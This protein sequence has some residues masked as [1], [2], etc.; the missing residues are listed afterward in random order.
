MHTDVSL[1]A[2]CRRISAAFA[3]VLSL[4]SRRS[5]TSIVGLSGADLHS[6]E[7]FW[8]PQWLWPGNGTPKIEAIAGAG[9]DAT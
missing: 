2:A 8:L 1:L 7:G 3:E 5:F 9:D 6:F 4:L